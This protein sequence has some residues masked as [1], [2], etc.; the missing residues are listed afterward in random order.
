MEADDHT[1]KATDHCELQNT[2]NALKDERKELTATL[3]EMDI[4]QER[5]TNRKAY[6]ASPEFIMAKELDGKIKAT[7]E[8]IRRLEIAKELKALCP[9]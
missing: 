4:W 1:K 8:Y 3:V 9:Q 7:P 6:Q 2:I 5:I